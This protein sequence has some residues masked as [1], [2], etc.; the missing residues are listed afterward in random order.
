MDIEQI[1]MEFG[2]GMGQAMSLTRDKRCASWAEFWSLLI[3]AGFKFEK[4]TLVKCRTMACQTNRYGPEFYYPS[5]GHYSLAV[6][7]GNLSFAYAYEKLVRR[8]SFIGTGLS[9][10]N[11]PYVRPGTTR[12]TQGRLVEGCEFMWEGE[13]V[14]VTTFRDDEKALIA[15]AY[16]PDPE[17]YRPSKIRRRFKITNDMWAAEKRLK[18]LC[19]KLK[20]E[21]VVFYFKEG[22]G[23]MLGDKRT[24][25]QNPVWYDSTGEVEPG[26]KLDEYKPFKA[27]GRAYERAVA[28]KGTDRKE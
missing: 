18:K 27:L 28:L 25:P 15:C 16:H 5:E 2:C 23:Y 14:K 10:D 6:R 21:G 7:S 13:K 24:D 3:S 22:F 9:Y 26:K 1:S 8:I 12:K 19:D 4:D 17:G 20:D 11:H